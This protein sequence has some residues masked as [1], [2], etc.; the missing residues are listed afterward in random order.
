MDKI[1]IPIYRFL[2][3]YRW[4]M[5][6]LLVATSA[7]FIFFGL[8]VKYEEDIS[9]LLPKTD[10]STNSGL[11]FNNLRVKDKIFLQITAKEGATVAPDELMEVCDCLVFN[12]LEKDSAS[13]CIANI[14]S[15]LDADM[16]MNALDYAL[17]NV[18]AFVDTSS[19]VWFDERLTPEAIDAQMALNAAVLE[20]DEEGNRSTAV[21]QDPCG[22]RYALLEQ[23]KAMDLSSGYTIYQQHFFCPDT[24]VCLAFLS[25]DFKTF[26]S[27]TGTHL[28]KM[29][30]SEIAAL[31]AQY[32]DVEIYFHGAPVQSVYNSRQIKQDLAI[33]LSI[34]LVI[35]CL[36][37]GLCFK[38]GSTLPMLLG[39][40]VYGAFAAL[41]L[42]YWLQ[43]GMSLL[44]LGLGAIVLGVALSYCLHV[45]THYKYVSDPEEVLKAQSTPV[46]LGCLTT[47]GAFMGLLFTQSSL[48]RDFGLFASFA[49][50]FTTLFSLIFLPQFFNPK[51]NKHSE[52]A[53]KWLEK[54]NSYPLDRQKWLVIALVVVSVVFTVAS[55]WV[56]FDPDL[57]H[58]GYTD[59]R[60]ATSQTLYAEKNHPNCASVY[61]AASALD[62]DSALQRS[63]ALSLTFDS[64]QQAGT[65]QSY[66]K[67]SSIFLTTEQQT[68]RIEAW[69]A[70]FTPQRIASIRQS[71]A[72]SARHYGLS[73]DAF[74]PF[75]MMLESDY[76]PS[77]VFESGAL[78]ESLLSN[79][80]EL[81]DGHYMVFTSALMPEAQKKAVSDAVSAQ[82]GAVVVDPF[83]YTSNMVELI[84]D[85]FNVVLA[86]S[87]VFVFLVLLIAFKSLSRAILAFI[88][89]GLSWF[90]VQGVMAVLGLPFNLINIV[91]AT[92]IFGIGVDYSIFVMDGLLAQTRRNDNQLLTY[93]KTAILF[94]AFVLIVVVLSMLFAIHPAI[95][96]I[97]LSTLIGMLST[98][99]LTYTLQPCL[100]RW[101]ASNRFFAKKF[102]RKPRFD[103][104]KD[105][106]D[107]KDQ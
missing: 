60:V 41:A 30:E 95:H 93:H 40:V 31:S 34:A 38:N 89:M 46:C 52:K 33:T 17:A 66:S 73:E 39:P 88:P 87:T 102:G 72:R 79:Y 96:S 92:F 37:I 4:L 24:T 14:L 26:D 58:I 9:K 36:V 20:N 6:V 16:M 45:L 65:L 22:L 47:I 12:L 104:D 25:P 8:Q 21:L 84:H 86:I 70:Y 18:P 74:E 85:D 28:V 71:I 98:I 80:I 35:I 1:F 69:K 105:Q 59:A 100:F 43:G 29:M 76:E 42:M 83:Y 15:A 63:Q 101:L 67:M 2:K 77:S 27:G 53:F 11:A 5:Y 91:I 82:A 55:F 90:V 62:L 48:L 94:S 103:A 50:I 7:L 75:F 3:A 81:T 106:K 19:Y 44:A 32:P 57:K 78:P 99:L 10:S 97:G 54:I 49:L 61:Y 107:P 68:Q 51:K 13:H 23:L 64:L 56:K